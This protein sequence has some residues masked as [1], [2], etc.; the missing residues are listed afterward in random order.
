MKIGLHPF[1]YGLGVGLGKYKI[2]F[3]LFYQSVFYYKFNCLCTQ[4]YVVFQIKS[5]DLI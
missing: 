2:L 5:L 4:N 3:N 1:M